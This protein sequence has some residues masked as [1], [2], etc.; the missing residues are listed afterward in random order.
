MNPAD[1]EALAVTA[2]GFVAADPE[3]LP[4]FLAL[5]GIDG[6]QVRKAAQEPGFLAGVL[7][8][9]LA[10]EP[11][12]RRFAEETGIDPAAVM[13]ARRALPSGDDRFDIST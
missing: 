3:L 9:I 13:T 2:L 1:A 7:D 12:V 5:T 11:T 6:A 10:H 4:R 8:C